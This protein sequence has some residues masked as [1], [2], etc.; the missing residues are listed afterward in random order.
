[1]TW[2]RC[3]RIGLPKAPLP[4]QIKAT[5]WPPADKTDACNG[6][7]TVAITEVIVGN[8]IPS[9]NYLISLEDLLSKP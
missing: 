7:L 8:T 6:D 1:M 3:P 4:F 2:S 9:K 5:N